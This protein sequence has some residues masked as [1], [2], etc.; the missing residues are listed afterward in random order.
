MNKEQYKFMFRTTWV[1]LNDDRIWSSFNLCQWHLTPSLLGKPY[2]T[3]F[4]WEVHQ[5]QLSWNAKLSKCCF[6]R[7]FQHS[8]S[9]PQFSP[10]LCVVEY[11][12]LLLPQSVF[13]KFVFCF[14]GWAQVHRT[15]LSLSPSS[16]LYASHFH[17]QHRLDIKTT[18]LHMKLGGK[19][20]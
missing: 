5:V 11:W 17:T 13:F 3:F 18:N 19:Q 9:T 1:R 4:L 2:L 7:S 12:K 15:D 8:N 20:N 14:S 16:S 10:W 6:R